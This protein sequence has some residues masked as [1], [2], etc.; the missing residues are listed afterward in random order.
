MAN[1]IIELGKNQDFYGNK[2]WKD[3]DSEEQKTADIFR[4]IS[5]IMLP[6]PIADQIPGGY[7][8]DGTRRPGTIARILQGGK[9]I[10]Q[11]GFQTRTLMQ[12][13]LRQV[14]MKITPFDLKTQQRYSEQEKRRA[15]ETLLQ[16]KGITKKFERTYIPK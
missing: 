2:I 1:L 16:E 9:G 4:H 10:E 13:I 15:L 3:S 11:G 14:G 6:P 7:R 12:E 8:A 5:K